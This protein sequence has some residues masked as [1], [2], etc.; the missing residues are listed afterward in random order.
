MAEDYV[1]NLKLGI[2]QEELIK[3]T[4]QHLETLYEQSAEQGDAIT[5]AQNKADEALS[6]AQGKVKAVSFNSIADMITALK[7]YSNKELKVGDTLYIIPT[8]VPDFWVSAFNTSQNTTNTESTLISN[9]YGPTQFGYYTISKLETQKADIDNMVEADATLPAD[10]I[11]TG[12]G[13]KK[14]KTSGKKISTATPTSSSTDATVPT[15]KAAYAV[16][17]SEA[18]KAKT[19]ANTYTDNAIAA[20]PNATQSAKGLM[21]P[22][23]KTRLDK[24]HEEWGDLTADDVGKV[25]DVTVNGTSVLNSAGVAAITIED[26]KT[27]YTEVTATSVTLGGKTYYA[28]AVSKDL[29]TLEVYNSAYQKIVTQNIVNNET[30]YYCVG[31]TAPATNKFYLRQI[32]G[33][34]VGTGGWTMFFR[35]E[36]QNSTYTVT[37][38][39][40]SDFE[41]KQ[42]FREKITIE[43]PG[44][45]DLKLKK[46]QEVRVIMYNA[47]NSEELLDYVASS[48]GS[49]SGETY[50]LNKAGYLSN[51]SFLYYVLMNN[52]NVEILCSQDNEFLFW[53]KVAIGLYTR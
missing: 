16:A 21:S 11:I 48:F 19:S 7:G 51:N 27:E 10:E 18:N 13:N 53:N 29:P 20:I 35:Y 25:K 32:S 23:D 42:G 6:A 40:E 5:A 50:V 1:T 8:D 24:L 2:T 12:A 45:T 41:Y 38:L 46:H 47:N 14:V 17:Q 26:L 43:F 44:N 31:T 34:G 52:D 9:N 49:A 28:I 4:E 33:G 22:T 30:L 3:N 36:D 37:K 39:T 15:S